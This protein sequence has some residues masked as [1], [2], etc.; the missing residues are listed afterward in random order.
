MAIIEQSKKIKL[1]KLKWER[2]NISL[3]LNRKEALINFVENK[4][5]LKKFAHIFE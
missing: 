4:D 2:V 1:V 3:G 5:N